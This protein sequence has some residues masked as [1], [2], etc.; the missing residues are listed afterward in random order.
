MT[1]LAVRKVAVN[2]AF[3]L[4]ARAVDMAGGLVTM[5]VIARYLGVKMFGDFSFVASLVGFLVSFSY[6]GLERAA[7]KKM[8]RDETSRAKDLGAII[9]ARWLMTSISVL[10]IACV[11]AFS[12]FDW[13]LTAAIAIATVAELMLAS[14]SALGSV[15]KAAQK[16]YYDTM[17]SAA[18][19]LAYLA[20]V[21]AVVMADLGFLSL[22]VAMAVGNMAKAGL[23][24]SIVYRKFARPVFKFDKEL[25]WYFL[26]NSWTLGVA[27]ILTIG[28]FR[29]G[30]IYLKYAKD[31]YD[32]GVFQAALSIIMPMQMLP[33]SI[34]I[35]M[36]PA[37]CRMG[38]ISGDSMRGSVE[39]ALVF[40]LSLSILVAVGIFIFSDLAIRLIYGQQFADSA[41]ILA[42]MGF[43][44]IPMFG[45]AILE[46][47]LISMDRQLDTIKSNGAAFAANVAMCAAL[48]PQYGAAGAAI[49]LFVSATLLFVFSYFYLSRRLKG[50]SLVSGFKGLL[51]GGSAA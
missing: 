25:I 48:T 46:Y 20:A 16:N 7:I 12:S 1:D 47:A 39:K 8:S 40:L 13:S 15:F 49:A 18:H 43:S 37:L 4:F 3:L 34:S 38:E 6:F 50:F 36:F 22:F 42:Y 26:T 11:T 23:V 10:A 2:A 44:V 32:V 28:V 35:A 31:A 30:T 29:F 17:A 24:I 51:S 41:M 21:V 33:M 19:R 14:T 27:I 9:I 45:A 5:I